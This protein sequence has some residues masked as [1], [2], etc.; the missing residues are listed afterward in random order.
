MT[1][2]MSSLTSVLT[3]HLSSIHIK[4]KQVAIVN[5]IYHFAVHSFL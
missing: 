1:I 4:T 3:E 2:F 5:A